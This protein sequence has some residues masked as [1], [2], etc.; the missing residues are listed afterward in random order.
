MIKFKFF[1]VFGSQYLNERNKKRLKISVWL[2][3]SKNPHFASPDSQM[4][5]VSVNNWD[6]IFVTLKKCGVVNII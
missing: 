3:F 2:W 4:N 5:I 6:S 1:L